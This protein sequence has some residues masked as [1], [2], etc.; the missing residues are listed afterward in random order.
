MNEK[1]IQSF[2]VSKEEILLDTLSRDAGRNA[3]EVAFETFPE[4][5]RDLDNMPEEE[6]EPAVRYA[7]GRLLE[8]LE[9]NRLPHTIEN[10]KHGLQ[11]LLSS[12]IVELA[13]YRRANPEN[14][15]AFKPKSAEAEADFFNDPNTSAE[16]L[17]QYFQGKYAER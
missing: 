9:E 13:E 14:P 6:R 5:G 8:T 3:L 7:L 17:K 12:G 2:T 10:A 15:P 11:Y 16:D 4:L 1:Q